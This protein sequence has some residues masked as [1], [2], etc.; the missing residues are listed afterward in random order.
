[1]A[2]ETSL[3]GNGYGRADAVPGQG[4]DGGVD[5]AEVQTLL[6][7]LA[8]ALTA[9]DGKKVAALWEVPALVI[10]VDGVIAVNALAEVERFFGG[11]RAQYNA[12]GI[13]DTRGDIVRLDWANERIAT[14]SVRWPYIDQEGREHGAEQSTYTLRR[15]DDGDL[16]IRAV[17]MHGVTE[18]H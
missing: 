7:K 16:K 4:A 18:R 6:D 15:D 10:G 2:H 3:E 13:V 9:G 5:R 8:R 12:Q 1:M 17:T 11:A 14:V